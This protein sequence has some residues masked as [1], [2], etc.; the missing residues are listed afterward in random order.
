MDKPRSPC[1]KTGHCRAN[2]HAVEDLVTQDRRVS[3]A[4]MSAL[5]GISPTSIHRI[6]KLDLY[7]VKKCTLFVPYVLD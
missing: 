5:S 7:L 2:V 3:I 1:H 6:L 4:S